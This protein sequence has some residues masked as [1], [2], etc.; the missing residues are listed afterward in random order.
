MSLIFNNA[1][2]KWNW[3]SCGCGQ[4]LYEGQASLGISDETCG[5]KKPI[6][7]NDEAFQGRNTIFS[8]PR[9]FVFIKGAFLIISSL[10]IH[11]FLHQQSGSVLW[12]AANL[13]FYF[14][15]S[16]S[17]LHAIFFSIYATLMIILCQGLICMCTHMTRSS[18]VQVLTGQRQFRAKVY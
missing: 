18:S 4:I 13:A 8:Q 10:C 11:P 17:L 1:D 16:F 12:I 9:C 3:F 5:T 15:F 6:D 2:R 14:L 7:N